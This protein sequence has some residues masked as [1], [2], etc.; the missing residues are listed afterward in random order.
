MEN[1]LKFNGKWRDYQQRILDNLSYH[2][3]DNKIH[4]VAAPGAGKTTLG[5]EVI[6]RINK[7]TIIFAPTI[8]IRNQWKQRIIDAF[9][10]GNSE[11]II[12]LNIREPKF[13]TVITY[14]SLLAAFCGADEKNEETDDEELLEEDDE[15]ENNFKRLNKEKANEI[16]NIVKKAKVEVLCF[17]EAH[18]L[19]NEWWKALMYFIDNLKPKQ[20]VSLTA[21]P[22]YDADTTEWERYSS[23]CGS[24]DEVISIPELVQNGDLCPHQDFI[25]FS[26][27]R[28]NESE[29]INKSLIRINNFV[30]SLYSN[31]ELVSAMQEY[32]SSENVETILEEPKNYVSVASFLKAAKKK[33]PN[34]FLEIFDSTE[35]DIPKFNEDQ[36]K[37]FL[38]FILSKDNK[39]LDKY[40]NVL[41]EIYGSAKVAGIMYNKS[42]YLSDNPKIKKQIA[43]SL[44]K[45]D[46][47]KDI[48]NLEANNL[49]D[50]LRMVILTDYIKYDVTD[51]S[52]LGVIPIWQTL[53]ER[54]DIS[55][56]VLTGSIILIPSKIKEQ[57]INLV[58]KCALED[59]VSCN[60]FDRDSNYLKVIAKGAK[61]SMIVE[62]ITQ[63]FNEG[64]ITV[65][66]GTQALLGEGWD[67]PCINS[68]ILSSTVSSYMLSNQMRGRAIRKDKNNPD[69]VSNIWH[70]A[71]VKILTTLETLKKELPSKAD[72]ETE[73]NI[74]IFDY[75][76][77]MQRFKGYEAPSFKEPHY[78]E[79]GIERILPDDFNNKIERN[80]GILTENNFIELNTGMKSMA[81]NRT[82]T[83]QL[84][85]KGLIK[86]YNAP[87]QSLRTGVST[88]VQ[89]KNFYYK[90]GYFYILF[91]WLTFFG[92]LAIYFLQ[93]SIW[94][95]LLC[96]IG[97]VVFMAQP[98]YKYLRC[99][100]P[101][102]IMR[103]IGI[104]ILETLYYMEC[105][106]TNMQRIDI[107]CK[108]NIVD[109]S[110]FFSVSNVSPEEN[111]LII[112]SF[113]EFLNPIENP[114]YLFIRKSKNNNM[115]TIDYHAIPTIIGQKKENTEIF[116]GL[117]NKYIGDCDIIYTRT[118]DGRKE[119]V[120]ARKEAFSS[121]VR[122]S[123]T[124]K[125]SR[126]E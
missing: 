114:R 63:M 123:K 5:I 90:G 20:T 9:L 45:L 115:Q 15:Q 124:K 43:N 78:I 23:L 94:L 59:Y 56:S 112:K 70:L 125:L 27:L 100:S 99:S 108:Q 34:N 109:G 50:K 75:L 76:Q 89:M 86:Q 95:L 81:V 126:F 98:T 13:I 122:D 12:S 103:Q 71:S 116:K 21:T 113:M 92:A 68:L 117:W 120:K 42:V 22:P 30:Q 101:E 88:T 32:L 67:A 93:V 74:Q 10:N 35:K 80:I 85:K 62:L 25:H 121:L 29:E 61:R 6:A 104:V 118:V 106:K 111:N 4:V 91:T 36:Q 48:V 37:L 44:G 77:L 41:D 2:L 79:N 1:V 96:V 24:I 47:I 54:Q 72:T 28:K 8:T 110:I 14:Q 57:F 51:C 73:P 49:K 82:E 26:L 55:L 52:V 53:K 11:D 33:I 16:I 87:A 97:F 65:M 19:R 17:D 119:L 64:L 58:K 7:P 107:Q 31:E 60:V 105:I 66:V 38:S 40:K 83:A 102:K 3:A 69:K 39:K 46:S 18:H 84:W